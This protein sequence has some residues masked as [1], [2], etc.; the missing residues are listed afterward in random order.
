MF[1]KFV[2]ALELGQKSAIHQSF[3]RLLACGLLVSLAESRLVF[4]IMHESGVL[5]S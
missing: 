4:L 2:T 1:W 5:T 3:T